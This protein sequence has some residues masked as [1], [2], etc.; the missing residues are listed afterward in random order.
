M[1]Y[2]KSYPMMLLEFSRSP[3]GCQGGVGLVIG[4]YINSNHL[5]VDLSFEIR[6]SG[7]IGEVYLLP[8][9]T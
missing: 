6:N 5:F 2:L 9:T 4:V 8:S 1:N 3:V 7:G